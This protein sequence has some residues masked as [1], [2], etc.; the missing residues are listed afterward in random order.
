MPW[1]GDGQPGRHEPVGVVSMSSVQSAN[2]I[3][4]ASPD[5]GRADSSRPPRNSRKGY[6]TVKT[7]PRRSILRP[8]VD[9]ALPPASKQIRSF[10]GKGG[11]HAVQEKRVRS[12]RNRGVDRRFTGVRLF[13][14]PRR[15]SRPVDPGRRGR[16]L[17]RRHCAGQAGE[18]YESVTIHTNGLTLKAQ[19]EVTLEPSHYGSS[20]CYIP[21]HDVG[22]CVTPASPSTGGYARGCVT[23]PSPVSAWSASPGTA[24]LVST[25]RT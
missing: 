10:R 18:Y 13:S 5:S 3:F 24:S 1:E 11:R 9:A 17:A 22:I 16:R 8:V 14:H 2:R 7:G 21:G 25:P 15:S 20:E 6:E 19:G 12:G 4:T 23:S